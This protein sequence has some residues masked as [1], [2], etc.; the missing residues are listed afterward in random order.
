MFET[1]TAFL[2]AIGINPA[3]LFAGVAGAIVRIAIQGKQ[4]TLEVLTGAFGGSLCA[5]YLAPLVARWLSLSP[6]DTSA[7]GG[8]AFVLGM[9]GLSIAEGLVRA[10]QRWAAN[11][12]F[13]KAGVIGDLR[14]AINMSENKDQ[15]DKSPDKE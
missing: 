12:K 10:A 15:A 8:L 14:D 5:V 6:L 4:M 2:A 1:L 9:V 13:P 7:N 3:H 11:P